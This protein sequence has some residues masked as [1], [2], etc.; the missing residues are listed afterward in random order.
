MADIDASVRE[1]LWFVLSWESTHPV[2]DSGTCYSRSYPELRGNDLAFSATTHENKSRPDYIF[3]NSTRRGLAMRLVAAVQ[4]FALIGSANSRLGRGERLPFERRPR[5]LLKRGGI[6]RKDSTFPR[7]PG[8][9]P[10]SF[11]NSI[12]REASLFQKTF[13]SF[14]EPPTSYGHSISTSSIWMRKILIYKDL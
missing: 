4:D 2:P 6:L 11:S 9:I 13:L 12:H 1:S 3:A 5:S 14:K 8:S 7:F 10:E